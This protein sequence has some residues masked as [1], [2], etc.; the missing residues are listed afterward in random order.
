MQCCTAVAKIPLTERIKT[1]FRLKISPSDSRF[2]PRLSELGSNSIDIAQ[3]LSQRLKSNTTILGWSGAAVFPKKP[4][5]KHIRLESI[6]RER[7][8]AKDDKN[9]YRHA[10]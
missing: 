8:R 4:L 2:E 9:G 5:T 7:S 3:P 1:F 10:L 6:D